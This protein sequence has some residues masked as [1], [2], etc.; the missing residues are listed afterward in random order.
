[1]KGKMITANSKD[2]NVTWNDST[3]SIQL[4]DAVSQETEI[5]CS[6]ASTFDG[7]GLVIFY[8]FTRFKEF[9]IWYNID[10]NQND[11]KI[12]DKFGI[13][14]K[15]ASTDAA[16]TVASK[17]ALAIDNTKDFEATSTDAVVTVVNTMGGECNEPIDTNSEFDF[18]VTVS[19]KSTLYSGIPFTELSEILDVEVAD[20]GSAVIYGLEKHI[21]TRSNLLYKWKSEGTY[22]LPARKEKSASWVDLT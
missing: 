16:A 13:E 21:V 8:L 15:I 7:K 19:G 22:Y 11:P 5:T 1:M 4:N 9:Y 14:V 2:L 18:T 20:D 10:D 12:R 17:T 3:L 6:A